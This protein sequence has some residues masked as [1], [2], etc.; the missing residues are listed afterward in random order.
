MKLQLTI[1][2]VG[3]ATAFANAQESGSPC[4]DTQRPAPAD[5]VT[6]LDTDGDGQVSSTEFDG[7]AE[8]F[9]QLDAN[10]DGYVSADEAPTGPPPRQGGQGAQ[11]GPPQQGSD[12]DSG[13]KPGFVSRFDADGDGQVSSTEF[14]GPAEHFTR[15][16]ANSDGYISEDEAP[17]GPPPQG[18]R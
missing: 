10:S 13:A 11:G 5:F 1:L 17:S 8:H 7:P 4:T 3:A 2:L 14:T 12:T 15:L 18:G 6:R 16:D 9:T